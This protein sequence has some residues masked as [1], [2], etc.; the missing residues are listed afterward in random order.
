MQ[1]YLA[2]KRFGKHARAQYERDRQRAEAMERANAEVGS[3]L[4]GEALG[5]RESSIDA[6]SSSTRVAAGDQSPDSRDPEK[7]ELPGRP[8]GSGEE[9]KEEG[10]EMERNDTL[11]TIRTTQSFGTRMGHALSGIEVRELSKEITRRRTQASGRTKTHEKGPEREKVFVVGFESECDTMN[12]HNWSYATR[13]FA[14]IMI[15]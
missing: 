1:S 12:P 6:V 11:E 14:T 3:G 13:I 9:D 7:A 2:Y 10:D 8:D 5:Q 4:D 15:A